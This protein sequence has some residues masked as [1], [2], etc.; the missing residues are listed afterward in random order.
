MTY[1]SHIMFNL[2]IINHHNKN[3]IIII[4]VVYMTQIIIDY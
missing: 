4:R 3:L 1:L 2:N